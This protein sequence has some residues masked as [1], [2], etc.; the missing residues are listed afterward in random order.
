AGAVPGAGARAAASRGAGGA[1]A[2]VARQAPGGGCGR[3]AI[4]RLDGELRMSTRAAT[5]DMVREIEE[6]ASFLRGRGVGTPAWGI[7]PGTGLGSLAG[8]MREQVSVPYRDIPHFPVSTVESHA[9]EWVFGT[10][11]DR[12]VVV[13][14]GRAH[15]YE[16]Y[17][18]KQ[19]TFPVRVLRALGAQALLLTGAAGGG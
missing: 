2:L 17:T 12:P 19:V 5:S 3:L 14:R 18:M 10:L 16:G 11:A 15:Y 13:L 9:G 1:G 8:A 6:A 4:A 7:V